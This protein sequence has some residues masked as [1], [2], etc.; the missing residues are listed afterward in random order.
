[1]L[2]GSV[3]PLRGNIVRRK[4][5]E[6]SRAHS[7]VGRENPTNVASLDVGRARFSSGRWYHTPLKVT[8][9][10]SLDM[11]GCWM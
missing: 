7:G 5:I 3:D 10:G 4:P 8:M 1:M 11:P 9:G 6:K 2:R